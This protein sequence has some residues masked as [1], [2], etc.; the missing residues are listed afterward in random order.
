MLNL[1]VMIVKNL[2]FFGLLLLKALFA[3]GPFLQIFSPPEITS[4]VSGEI[5]QGQVSV[6]GNTD[7]DGFISYEI[8]FTYEQEE[9]ENWFLITYS[10]DPVSNAA[11]AVWDTTVITDGNY[12]LRLIVEQ[13]DGRRFEEVID[14]LRVRNYS[15]VESETPA[16]GIDEVQETLP[17]V[18][19][20][21]E[22]TNI[23]RPTEFNINPAEI[24]SNDLLLGIV[25]G[26]G[27]VIVLFMLSILY[28]LIKKNGRR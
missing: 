4:P 16:A 26:M 17:A 13:E 24:H 25:W 3:A 14:N 19:V 18:Q 20:T 21:L 8:S 11:L 28:F 5:L 7:V 10:S 15:A 2:S 22:S 23:P 12:K 9:A 27:G 6:L 1:L